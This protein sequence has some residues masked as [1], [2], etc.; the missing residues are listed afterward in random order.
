MAFIKSSEEFGYKHGFDD[1]VRSI[2]VF[3]HFN[4]VSIWQS[5]AACPFDNRNRGADFRT[6]QRQV[7]A[8]RF[9]VRPVRLAPRFDCYAHRTPRKAWEYDAY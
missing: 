9:C 1:N 5:R 7:A 4:C 3:D 6:D 8:Y 2:T